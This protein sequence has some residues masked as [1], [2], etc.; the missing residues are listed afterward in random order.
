MRNVKRVLS[1]LIAFAVL[2]S[3]MAFSVSA[4]SFPDV[5][6]GHAN[7]AAIEQLSDLGIIQGDDQ[8]NFNPDNNVNRAEFTALVMR[9]IGQSDSLGAI[10]VENA[11]FPDLSDSSVSWAIGDITIARNMGIINGYED[12]TFRPTDPV[13]Y[14]EAV[15]MIVCALGYG[16]SIAS[17][18]DAAQWFQPYMT[19]ATEMGFTKRAGG[20]IGV[21]ATRGCI[22]QMLYDAKDVKTLDSNGKVSDKSVLQDKLGST[23]ATGI[24]ISDQNTSL[25]SPDLKIRANEIQILTRENGKE[26]IYTYTVSNNTYKNWLGYQ[27]ELYYTEDRSDDNRVLVSATKK[28]TKEVNVKAKDILKEES[29]A[30]SLVYYPSDSAKEKRY[31]ISDENVVIYN[32]KLYGTSASSSKFEPSMLPTVGDVTLI[33]A[34]G[35][36]SYDVIKIN[37]YDVYFAS[38]VSSSDYSVTDRNSGE[39]REALVLN[40]NDSAST[41]KIQ[42]VSGKETTFGNI[43]AK[44]SVVSHKQSNSAN[45]GELLRTAVVNN[46]T[47]SG[48]VFSINSSEIKVGN[49][50]YDVSP[51][52]PWLLYSDNANALQAP[53]VGDNVTVYFDVNNAVVA[54]EKSTTTTNQQYGYIMSA[55][56]ASDLDNDSLRIRLLAENSTKPVYY[57][58]NK[59][60]KIAGKSYSNANEFENALKEYVSIQ[61]TDDNS[62]VNL[63]QLVKFTTK[64][65]RGETVIDE[66][67]PA[68]L[69][70][71]GQE[72]KNDVL[73][74]LS[75]IDGRMSM[76]YTSS[77]KQL[78]LVDADG[79]V[80]SNGPS[81]TLAD[82]ITKV[83]AVPHDRSDTSEYRRPTSI[84]TDFKNNGLYNVEVFDVSVSKVPKVVVLYGADATTAVDALTPV[85]VIDEVSTEKDGPDGT[86]MDQLSVIR[87]APSGSSTT[88]KVWLS[89]E[90][91][92]KKDELQK[93]D[94]VRCGTDADGYA[95]IKAEDVLW[96]IDSIGKVSITPDCADTDT[97]KTEWEE[98]E[99]T[100][101]NAAVY[102]YDDA[103]QNL[104]LS[105]DI[106]NGGEFD[107]NRMLTI[108]LSNF[109]STK[110]LKYSVKNDTVTMEPDPPTGA[111][112]LIAA[113]GKQI[114]AYMSKG[115]VKLFVTIQVEN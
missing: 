70:S 77:N 112:A 14:E 16:K 88:T 56:S 83:F 74:R 105:E 102:R 68:T 95:T 63:H 114:F 19:I 32:D 60:S 18:E 21:A 113:E 13:A 38:V 85:Y 87:V 2:M 12:G 25:T 92:I 34:K 62:A 51:A 4:A 26:N 82:N 65:V 39:T 48:E 35:T 76:K 33:D 52:A 96:N 40:I 8:G 7:K 28:N 3:C 103:A 108:S 111:E 78:K 44:A 42:D 59:N 104:V 109:S 46:T 90:S 75:A 101:I 94:I 49:T 47:K 86:A 29:T 6:D 58:T 64:S 10:S 9:F 17:V 71:G 55:A 11:P 24:I 99:F 15:K 84:A 107:N 27:V 79:N 91:E 5:P 57:N 100:V 81:V 20:A 67:I 93:G 72:I 31:S 41:L 22:A 80:V 61:N 106:L 1:S 98:T 36:G 37:S 115:K 23:K 50:A 73:T 30:S 110:F 69:A 45:G 53:S 89:S 97:S 66:I 43:K 54:Y